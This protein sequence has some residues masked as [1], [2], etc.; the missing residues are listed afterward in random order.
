MLPLADTRDGTVD[1]ALDSL[2]VVA[3]N[4]ALAKYS[5]AVKAYLSDMTLPCRSLSGG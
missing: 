4:T 5:A 1:L 3:F 2:R